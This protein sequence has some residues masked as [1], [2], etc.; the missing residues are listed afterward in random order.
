MTASLSAFKKHLTGDPMR[1]VMA[2]LNLSLFM[3]AFLLESPEKVLAGFWTI[4]LA[5]C[6]LIT[7]YM[8]LAGREQLSSMPVV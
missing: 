1:T 7:D 3:T 8:A 5:P 6:G 2:A 4:Q